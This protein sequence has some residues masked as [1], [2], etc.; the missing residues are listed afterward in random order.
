MVLLA[1]EYKGN[2]AVYLHKLRRKEPHIDNI[3]YYCVC[4]C[5]GTGCRSQFPGI[6]SRTSY[7]Y[8]WIADTICAISANPPEYLHCQGEQ[9]TTIGTI[10]EAEASISDAPTM[11]PTKYEASSTSNAPSVH[12]ADH[13]DTLLPSTKLDAL[14]FVSWDRSLCPIGHCQ[15]DCDYDEDCAGDMVCYKGASGPADIPGCMD[16]GDLFPVFADF[17]V[18]NSDIPTTPIPSTTAS[19]VHGPNQYPTDAPSWLGGSVGGL[20]E[21]GSQLMSTQV[22]THLSNTLSIPTTGTL[23][24]VGWDPTEVLGLCQGDC[25]KDEDCASDLICL[26]RSRSTGVPGC[27]DSDAYIPSIS[28]FCAYKEEPSQP[29]LST[30]IPTAASSN[31]PSSMDELVFVGWDPTEPLARCQGDCDRDEDCAGNMVC[32]G[33]TSGSSNVPGCIRGNGYVPSIS[34]FCV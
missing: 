15:G 8:Q 5:R 33:R 17:C 34:D 3:S 27:V 26:G 32:Y 14:Q 2:I 9:N 22:P 29:S 19:T 6:Y 31:A 12:C 1:R 18:N 7:F 13:Y 4:V 11:H 20:T 21:G 28:N 16:N 25:D 30:T 24:F 10:I 23:E